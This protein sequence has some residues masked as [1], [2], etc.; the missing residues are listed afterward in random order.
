MMD[1]I[2][3]QEG[4]MGLFDLLKRLGGDPA[5]DITVP[6]DAGRSIDINQGIEEMKDRPEAMLLDVRDPME[7]ADGHIP[8][9]INVPVGSIAMAADA[10]PDNDKEKPV[11][12]YCLTGIRSRKAAS[13]LRD[14]GFTDVTDLGGINA[15]RGEL[16]T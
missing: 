12:V 7:Y 9:S 11:Y 1:R 2:L 13:I 3:S 4:Q 14:S 15:W 6:G 16:E 5:D 10:M 8:G